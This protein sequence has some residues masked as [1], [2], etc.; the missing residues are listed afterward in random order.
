[1]AV[2]ILSA[3]VNFSAGVDKDMVDTMFSVG[4]YTFIVDVVGP[5]SVVASSMV[6]G[7]LVLLSVEYIPVVVV[8]TV[9]VKP[10][11][12]VNGVTEVTI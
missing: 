11:V 10:L 8:F 5:V 4:I 7:L 3:E 2:E 6:V 1:M 9:V 12:D